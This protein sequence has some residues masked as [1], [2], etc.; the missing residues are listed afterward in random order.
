MHNYNIESHNNGGGQTVQRYSV[1]LALQ[2]I[3]CMPISELRFRNDA[4]VNTI[5]RPQMR[6]SPELTSKVELGYY[7]A[8]GTQ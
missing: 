5:A 8:R 6:N 4:C 1:C 2:I 3:S 7:V